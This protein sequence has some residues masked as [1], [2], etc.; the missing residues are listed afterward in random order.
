[1]IC[2]NQINNRPEFSFSFVPSSD[3]KH[4]P[5]TRFKKKAGFID[6]INVFYRSSKF[7][8]ARIR[9]RVNLFLEQ[10]F[11]D[12]IGIKTLLYRIR[13]ARKATVR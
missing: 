12:Y 2:P 9:G 8:S 7:V 4:M 13:R 1:M 10:I 6:L 3:A 5:W 11:K